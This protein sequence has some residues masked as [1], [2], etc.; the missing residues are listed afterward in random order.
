MLDGGTEEDAERRW[1]NALRGGVLGNGIS[2]S[3]SGRLLLRMDPC[4]SDRYHK[5]LSEYRM[6]PGLTES[7]EILPVLEGEKRKGQTRML[8]AKPYGQGEE[9]EAT[10][11]PREKR[12]LRVAANRG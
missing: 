12:K 1:Q 7:T 9:K 10:V 6:Y 4:H 11:V 3:H 5:I 8:G 2:R